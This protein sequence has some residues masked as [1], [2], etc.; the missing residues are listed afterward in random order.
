MNR[1]TRLI[2][3]M[4]AIA[5]DYQIKFSKSEEHY[6]EA[7]GEIGALKSEFGCVGAGLGGGFI[8][9]SELHVMN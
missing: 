8:N 1:P 6:Y 7:M 5:S 9:T 3:E 4:N 2:E